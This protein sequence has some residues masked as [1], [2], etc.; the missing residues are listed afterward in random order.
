[1]RN[2]ESSEYIVANEY[3]ISVWNQMVIIMYAL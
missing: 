2:F 3:G 1:M